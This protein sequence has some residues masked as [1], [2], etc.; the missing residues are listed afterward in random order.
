MTERISVAFAASAAMRDAIRT[1][2]SPLFKCFAGA[3][4]RNSMA[5]AEIAMSGIG[6]VSM[7]RAATRTATAIVRPRFF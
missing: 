4:S 6:R 7:K 1:G 3:A 5:R 2:M